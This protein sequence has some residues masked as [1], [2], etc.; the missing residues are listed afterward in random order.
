MTATVA[1]AR[2]PEPDRE[3]RERSTEPPDNWGIHL[4][5]NGGIFVDRTSLYYV[6]MS[7][8]ALELALQLVRTGTVADLAR[9]RSR[10]DREPLADTRRYLEA[11]LGSH[12]ITQS[13]QDGALAGGIRVTG[14]TEAY[15]PLN[16]SLQLTNGCNLRCSF[17]YASSGDPFAVE[18]SAEDWTA[19]L[20]RL[21]TAG[22][23]AVTLTGGEPTIVPEFPRILATASA[24]IDNVDIFTN[25]LAWSDAAVDFAAALGNVRIQVSVDG[26]A[27][28][29]D[30]LR[31]KAGSYRRALETIRRL[32][33]AGVTVFV[34]MTVT[35]ANHTDVGA[36]IEQVAEA[37]ARLF[38][39]GST[40]PVGRGDAAEFGLSEPQV[41]AVT[42]QF[43][44]A[45]KLG[46]DIEVTGWDRCADPDQEFAATGLDVEFLTPGY[47]SWH[48]RADGLVTPCQVEEKSF[49]DIRTESLTQ[50]GD[51]R[52]LAAIRDEAVGCAC[53][54]NI[55]LEETAD[56]PFG[57]R[58][59]PLATATVATDSPCGGSGCCRG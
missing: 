33:Q 55:R 21:A 44:Q 31:G 27:E 49:G 2:S 19:V 37:G 14:S 46:L 1:G 16:A 12:P 4:Q 58:P 34:A 59:G 41:A 45:G 40:V 35:P 51:P 43:V 5:P 50:I 29:H 25:G 13:W 9:L 53:V 54:R 42:E 39:A 23:A 7:G 38:R 28:H 11:L 8:L 18:C 47:L 32:S 57:L 17:C 30:L 10:L 24:L 20:E 26:R 52:R 36:V 3:H 56:L 15:L 48:I 22:T 6:R